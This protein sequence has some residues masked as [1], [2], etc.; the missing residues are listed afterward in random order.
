ML[1]RENGLDVHVD[2]RYVW[3]WGE[4]VVLGVGVGRLCEITQSG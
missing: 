1:S 2:G 3:R 4:E